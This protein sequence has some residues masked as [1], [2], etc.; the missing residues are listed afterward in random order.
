[1]MEGIFNFGKKYGGYIATGIASFGVGYWL[2]SG[3]DDDS[4]AQIESGK[5][6]KKKKNKKED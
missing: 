5:K 3:S 4:C 6:K 2:G 1:M